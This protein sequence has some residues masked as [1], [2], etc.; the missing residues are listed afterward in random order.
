MEALHH[1]ILPKQIRPVHFLVELQRHEN[2]S[3]SFHIR[4]D[5][6]EVESLKEKIFPD[7]GLNF[8]IKVDPKA[9]NT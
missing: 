3:D 9:N 4:V 6:H 5:Q 8:K 7:Q 1:K 2:S